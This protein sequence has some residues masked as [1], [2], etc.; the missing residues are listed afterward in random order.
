MA[1]QRVEPGKW[2]NLD[3]T[4]DYAREVMEKHG[5]DILP[6]E[7]KLKE[8]QEFGLRYS[9]SKN[10]GGWQNFRKLLGQEQVRRENGK[11]KD[12]QYTI[13]Q[14]RKIIKEN[15]LNRLPGASSLEKI[16][17]SGLSG[18]IGKYHGGFRKFRKLLKQ[19]QLMVESGTWE[20][21]DYTMAEVRRV[22][23][24]YSLDRLPS[25][26][27]LL[28]LGESSLGNAITRYHGGFMLFRTL[29]AEEQV[30]TKNGQWQDREFALDYAKQVMIDNGW[31][32]LPGGHK[33]KEIGENKFSAVI[34]KYY[35][36]F[37]AF[38]ELLAGRDGRPQRNELLD[39]LDSYT[40]H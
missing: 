14:A 7:E 8:L 21:L 10:H 34:A 9:I 24:K 6:G 11:W 2:K 20:N 12:L 3:S 1:K 4:L 18:A 33:L 37:P 28:N 39:L 26:Y 36:G 27:K 30:R 23:A 15:G 22:M 19:P 25:Q 40:G 13:E 31:D 16:G 29:M 17:G 32:V 5:F 38:R 35:G